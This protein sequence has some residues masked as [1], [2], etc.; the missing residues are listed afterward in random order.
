MHLCFPNP[1]HEELGRNSNNNLTPKEKFISELLGRDT[2][3]S[4]LLA[5][6]LFPFLS[7]FLFLSFFSYLN[8]SMY[9]SC[10]L[11]QVHHFMLLCLKNLAAGALK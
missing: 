8:V 7:F 10:F 3:A 2:L 4:C 6:S 11:A 1:I 9:L 5:F